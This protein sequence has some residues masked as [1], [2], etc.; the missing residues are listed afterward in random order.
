[1]NKIGQYEV[2]NSKAVKKI[3]LALKEQFCFDE[4]LDYAFLKSKKDKVLIINKEVDLINHESLRVDALGLYFGK[5]YADGFR[6]SIEGAQ[7][8]GD[9]CGC[10]VL[11]VSREQKHQWLKGQD[12]LVSSDASFVII[13]SEGDFLGCAKV[14]NGLA[15]NSVPSARTLKVV[16]E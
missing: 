4:K 13:K 11:S 14:K 1:M 12:L 2:L 10:N 5:F 6:L 8:I 15:F 7:L 9:K 16:N 3:M